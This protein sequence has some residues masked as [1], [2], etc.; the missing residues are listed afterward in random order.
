MSVWLGVGCS[1]PT[2]FFGKGNL[3]PCHFLFIRKKNPD[4][5][6]GVLTYSKKIRFTFLQRLLLRL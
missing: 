3:A 2:V 4:G 5:N 1:M 6:I